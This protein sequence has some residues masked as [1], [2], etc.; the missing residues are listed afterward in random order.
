[1][2]KALAADAG[3]R[4]QGDDPADRVRGDACWLA[5]RA[6]AAATAFDFSRPKRIGVT[7]FNCCLSGKKTKQTKIQP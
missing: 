5:G 7:K 1:M 4:P 6:P 2:P 3:L